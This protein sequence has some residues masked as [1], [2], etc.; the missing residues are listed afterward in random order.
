MSRGEIEDRVQLEVHITVQT[1][2]DK[3]MNAACGSEKKGKEK[4]PKEAEKEV[5]D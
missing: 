1:Q 2:D 3:G 4:I 5:C